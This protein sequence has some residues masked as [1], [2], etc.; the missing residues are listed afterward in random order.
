MLL[1]RLLSFLALLTLCSGCR[2]LKGNEAS[3]ISAGGGSTAASVG[4][5]TSTT[6]AEQATQNAFGIF[7]GT[8]VSNTSVGQGFKLATSARLASV[9]LYLQNTAGSAA[10]TVLVRP[11]ICCDAG[12]GPI[13][14][15]ISTTIST[16]LSWQEFEF[17]THPTLLSATDAPDGY[18]VELF[19]SGENHVYHHTAGSYANGVYWFAALTTWNFSPA[20]DLMFR[21]N[22][23][24]D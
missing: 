20:L 14:A 21:V 8:Q 12:S 22:V 17:P 9:E 23:C 19:P 4:C 2:I 6:V 24:N 18:I 7:D 16:T 11:Y 5:T 1:R 13:S 10:A 3:G 15:S